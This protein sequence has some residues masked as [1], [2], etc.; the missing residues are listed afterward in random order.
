[1]KVPPA[2]CG[3][4]SEMQTGE[5]LRSR[6]SPG[7]ERGRG[8]G[9][10]GSALRLPP[11]RSPG[12]H[13]SLPRCFPALGSASSPSRGAASGL[14]IQKVKSGLFF[15]FSHRP[16]FSFSLFKS[17]PDHIIAA[18]TYERMVSFIFKKVTCFLF[19]R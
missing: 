13:L 4:G 9:E 17:S 11:R 6:A 1:M 18:N 8:G 14:R 12:G 10:P 16:F 3:N 2:R 7:G 19:S 15:R 5:G